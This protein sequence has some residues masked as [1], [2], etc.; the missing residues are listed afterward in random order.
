M[1][2]Y[3]ARLILF[4]WSG[5][6][7]EK[8]KSQKIGFTGKNKM[9]RLE[10]QIRELSPSVKDALFRRLT[11]AEELGWLRDEKKPGKVIGFEVDLDDQE[12]SGFALIAIQRHT[13]IAF[14]SDRDEYPRLILFPSLEILFDPGFELLDLMVTKKEF[15]DKTFEGTTLGRGRFGDMV[16]DLTPPNRKMDLPETVVEQIYNIIEEEEQADPA[17]QAPP[18]RTAPEPGHPV[19]E[20][21]AEEEF[22][23]EE[24]PPEGFDEE[25]DNFDS[26]EGP[27]YDDY[28]DYS[29]P[30]EEPEPE[31]ELTR[32]EKLKAQTFNS[33]SEV[34]DFV[35]LK[36][37]IN[38]PLAVTLANKAMQSRVSPQYRVQLAVNIFCKL[39]DENKI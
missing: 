15:E 11:F 6:I 31:R 36:L 16:K 1:A 33:L 8:G 22:D 21:P 19:R 24:G 26:Y 25:P 37:G 4:G 13:V 10:S 17:L 38:R 30:I 23:Q 3:Q 39:I 12:L 9:T 35:V 14:V 28:E 2:V 29:D 7:A 27:G 18:E 20:S 5:I 32:S 34:I